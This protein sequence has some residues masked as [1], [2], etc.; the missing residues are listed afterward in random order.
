MTA[1]GD[2]EINF[3]LLGAHGYAFLP[4]AEASNT[5]A[6]SV[7][8]HRHLTSPS[9][10]YVKPSDNVGEHLIAIGLVKHLVPSVAVDVPRYS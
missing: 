4:L 6:F 7:R 3:G 1:A 5:P 9:E 10:D 2:G 8:T